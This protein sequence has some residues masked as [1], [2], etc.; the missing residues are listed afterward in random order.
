MRLCLGAEVSTCVSV[1]VMTRRVRQ[2]LWD[3]ASH[4]CK[5]CRGVMN[6][7]DGSPLPSSTLPARVC[8]RA[9]PSHVS[10]DRFHAR[11]SSNLGVEIA[12]AS[13]GV[14]AFMGARGSDRGLHLVSP[15]CLVKRR[16]FP[17]SPCLPQPLTSSNLAPPK[18][19]A[20][21]TS[22][23][24]FSSAAPRTITCSSFLAASKPPD[25]SNLD[26]PGY[27]FLLP[28]ALEISL[29]LWLQEH[30]TG[31]HACMRACVRARSVCGVGGGRLRYVCQRVCL[32]HDCTLVQNCVCGCLICSTSYD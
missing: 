28:T 3:K 15:A 1:A 4:A 21:F 2:L 6:F 22:C 26:V 29:T 12:T 7:F 9:E 27:R 25:P 5:S 24:C 32:L 11:N 17:L 8:Y 20:A 23:S 30:G 14:N 13:A 18:T 19:S 31:A 10:P 16:Y